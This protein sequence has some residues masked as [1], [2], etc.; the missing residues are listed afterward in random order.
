M[1]QGP[2]SHLVMPSLKNE[3]AKHREMEK[4]KNK[5][6]GREQKRAGCDR[7]LNHRTLV[8]LLVAVFQLQGFTRL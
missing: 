4:P 2:Q 1:F 5:E 7:L 8:L 3:K 6:E